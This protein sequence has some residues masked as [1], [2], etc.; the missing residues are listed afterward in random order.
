MPRLP[1]KAKLLQIIEIQKRLA[2]LGLD[3]SSI[4]ALITEETMPLLGAEGAAIELLEDNFM[5]YRATAGIAQVH[6][7]LKIPAHESLSGLCALSAKSQYC[8]DTQSDPRVNQLACRTIG[9]QSMLLV[10]LLHSQQVVGVLKVMSQRPDA[11]DAEDL[12]ILELISE[13]TGA[14]MY[15][16]TRFST[17]SLAYQA[18]HDAMTR[19]ANRSL[20]ME[21]LRSIFAE[22]EKYRRQFAVLIIDMDDL[23]TAND[24]H[25]HLFGDELLTEL[26]N[27]IRHAT[28]PSD[29]LARLGGDEFAVIAKDVQAPATLLSL[30]ARLNRYIAPA[31]ESTKFQYQLKASIGGACYPADGDTLELLLDT[32]DRRMYEVKK[33]RK[34]VS[35]R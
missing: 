5:V 35:A 25:G 34:N 20:F 7:G 29:L 32:A 18:T 22:A 3:L 10:P 12:Q 31:F 6:L 30:I 28:Q 19:L 23:K 16:A 14:A 26:A 9:I 21:K 24:T 8:A 1:S 27:R 4:M 15:F 2:G 17:C 13:Q 11:F 33:Q